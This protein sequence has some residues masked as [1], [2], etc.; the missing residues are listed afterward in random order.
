MFAFARLIEPFIESVVDSVAFQRDSD[1]RFQ[2]LKAVVFRILLVQFGEVFIV[3]IPN[4]VDGCR[5]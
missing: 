2:C 4:V 5:C 1:L 3:V